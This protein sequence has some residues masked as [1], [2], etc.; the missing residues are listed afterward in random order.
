MACRLRVSYSPSYLWVVSTYLWKCLLEVPEPL[1]VSLLNVRTVQNGY[2][3][4]LSHYFFP[5]LTDFGFGPLGLSQICRIRFLSVLHFQYILRLVRLITGFI[6][7]LLIVISTVLCRLRP[8]CSFFRFVF[9]WVWRVSPLLLARAFL[10]ETTCSRDQWLWS[11]FWAQ[12][13]SSSLLSASAV[14]WFC[15]TRLDN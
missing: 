2:F 1:S 4:D 5:S 7:F 8:Y 10:T 11:Q 14:K 12:Q 3:I 6:L 15:S 13:L 9:S